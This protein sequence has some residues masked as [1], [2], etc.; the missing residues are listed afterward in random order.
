MTKPNQV[1]KCPKCNNAHEL[2]IERRPDGD[3]NCRSCGWFGSY[4]LCLP[5][6]ASI[7]VTAPAMEKIRELADKLAASQSREAVLLDALK[8]VGSMVTWHG[9][10]HDGNDGIFTYGIVVDKA[11]E[12]I[13]KHEA[14]KGK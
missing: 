4:S 13:A 2:A 3:A 1:P 9:H 12:A 14:M 10:L 11:R 8:F 6:K 7:S 5:I